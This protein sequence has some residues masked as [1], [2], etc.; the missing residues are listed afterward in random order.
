MALDLRIK[1]KIIYAHIYHAKLFLA[2]KMFIK[3]RATLNS[4]RDNDESN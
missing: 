3:T 1:K 4:V 2:K